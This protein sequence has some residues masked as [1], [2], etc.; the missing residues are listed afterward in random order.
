LTVDIESGVRGGQDRLRTDFR[1]YRADWLRRPH[2]SSTP[3]GILEPG[4]PRND[5]TTT[6]ACN[7]VWRA[8]GAL[9][10]TL[11]T[12][13]LTH[14]SRQ[15]QVRKLH[16]SRNPEKASTFRN[17]ATITRGELQNFRQMDDY[18]SSAAPFFNQTRGVGRLVS[19]LN[20]HEIIFLVGCCGILS[21]GSRMTVT[22]KL[23]VAKLLSRFVTVCNVALSLPVS[24]PLCRM[25][26]RV[27]PRRS[28]HRLPRRSTQHS[29][30][31]TTCRV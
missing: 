24:S 23:G 13:F 16:R 12:N 4:I 1:A 7:G 28:S 15:R 22:K 14:G 17:N 31:T 11:F 10:C 19:Q 27:V 3:W 5:I 2:G 6:V 29:T 26:T 8:P 30:F 20:A 18:N 21:E 9:R 25:S